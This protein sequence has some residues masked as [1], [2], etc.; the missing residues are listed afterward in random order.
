MAIWIPNSKEDEE[1]PVCYVPC[2]PRTSIADPKSTLSA[3]PPSYPGE[4]NLGNASGNGEGDEKYMHY[5]TRLLRWNN[6]N[7]SSLP[8]AGA[9][10][11]INKTTRFGDL[12]GYYMRF[13]A[14]DPV[15]HVMAG[16]EDNDSVFA[17][18]RFPA[19]MVPFAFFGARGDDCPVVLFPF[20]ERTC[21]FIPGDADPSFWWTPSGADW[22]NIS[23]DLESLLA[24]YSTPTSLAAL[25]A[26][27][28]VW[29]IDVIAW[30]WAGYQ[31]KT[32]GADPQ[33]YL[34]ADTRGVEDCDVYYVAYL[35]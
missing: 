20:A 1:A 28:Q 13:N 5:C 15:P 2:L 24:A 26:L 30:M 16:I 7:P 9:P 29:N 23:S 4:G 19:D 12:G 11:H 21:G 6:I 14:S 31:R 17:R 25:A 34:G 27:D 22:T 10:D 18:Y 32:G 8:P 33:S 3:N 35:Y